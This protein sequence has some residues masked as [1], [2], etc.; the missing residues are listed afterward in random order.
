MRL[1]FDFL[2]EGYIQRAQLFG[3]LLYP[4]LKRDVN[5]F[6]LKIALF[7]FELRFPQC[8]MRADTRH[9]FGSPDRLGNVVDPARFERFHLVVLGFQCAQEDHGNVARVLVFLEL[10]DTS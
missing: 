8:Q 5:G 4:F 7:E 2:L 9:D 1:E 6:Q 3:A 10:P